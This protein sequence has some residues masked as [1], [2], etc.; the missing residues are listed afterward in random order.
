MPPWNDKSFRNLLPSL[1]EER[2]FQSFFAL[3][4]WI[5][6]IG[7]VYRFPAA[8]PRCRNR[9]HRLSPQPQ[10]RSSPN[11]LPRQFQNCLRRLSPRGQRQHHRKAM[12]LGG[13]SDRLVCS[14]LHTSGT[15]AA[16]PHPHPTPHQGR[17]RGIANAIGD[18]SRAATPP[19]LNCR[20]QNG[21]M[22]IQRSISNTN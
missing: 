6:T 1:V 9:L 8:D 3:P 13:D 11:T 7:T 15:E 16:N 10:L 5:Y 21:S 22:D 17:I 19:E 20:A 12:R 4:S 14:I 2:S 18:W